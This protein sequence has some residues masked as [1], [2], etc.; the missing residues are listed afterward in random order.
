MIEKVRRLS[1]ISS[2]NRRSN[3]QLIAAT[4]AM[5]VLRSIA[6]F[7]LAAVA[8]IGGAWLVWQGVREH[9]GWLFVGAGVIALGAYGRL[10][11]GQSTIRLDLLGAGQP[12][13]TSSLQRCDAADAASL[14]ERNEILRHLRNYAASHKLETTVFPLILRGV[15]LLGVESVTV[16][17]PVR[18]PVM[19]PR[20][21]P[22][23]RND[24]SPEK[25][26]VGL[27]GMSRSSPSAP[28]PVTTRWRTIMRSTPS[29]SSSTATRACAAGWPRAPRTVRQKHRAAR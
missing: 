23:T 12:A 27:T 15:S 5:T 17:L 14:R 3:R 16:P 24:S 21:L 1:R 20:R 28:E 29:A 10:D 4:A 13:N 26:S 25:L 19:C 6:L 11:P 2:P 8:E 7:A 22:T 18:E 9:R